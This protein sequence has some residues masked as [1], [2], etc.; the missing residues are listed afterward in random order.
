M[1]HPEK[2]RW[3]KEGEDVAL[4]RHACN[5]TGRREELAFGINGTGRRCPR[6][7]TKFYDPYPQPVVDA[8]AAV[9]PQFQM[10]QIPEEIWPFAEWL[11]NRQPHNVL[12]IGVRHGGTSALWH[13]LCTGLVVGIDWEGRD[14]LGE[15]NTRRL[16]AEM[17]KTYPRFT[18]ILGDSQ[19]VETITR[20]DIGW[21][22]DFIFI[23]GDHSYEGVKADFYNYHSLLSAGGCIA[24]HDIVDTPTT[25]NAGQ[26]VFRF[27]N[28]LKARY[29]GQW[30]EFCVNGE[31]GGIGAIVLS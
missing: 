19:L 14:G 17:M 5:W 3:T 27:W 18:S 2:L 20:A 7:S 15:E 13:G 8:F 31:W 29:P 6:C 10:E 28:E 25:R 26:G 22:Y 21:S 24:F 1:S 30:K 4:F 9:L 23:D 16:H 12:E 11:W